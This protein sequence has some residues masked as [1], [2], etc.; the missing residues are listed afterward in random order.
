[1]SSIKSQ[2]HATPKMNHCIETGEM[3]ASDKGRATNKRNDI[4][5]IGQYITSG[6]SLMPLRTIYIPNSHTQSANDSVPKKYERSKFTVN[7]DLVQ[8]R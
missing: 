2:L 3:A 5:S 1:M 7:L 4:A 6:S 8:R